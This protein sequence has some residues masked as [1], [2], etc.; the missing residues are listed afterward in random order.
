LCPSLF[1]KVVSKPLTQA[2]VP[3]HLCQVIMFARTHICAKVYVQASIEG[4]E[5]LR[6]VK[7]VRFRDAMF[8]VCPLRGHTKN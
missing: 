4:R 8:F 2:S 5:K 6:G 1:S 7:T 3:C